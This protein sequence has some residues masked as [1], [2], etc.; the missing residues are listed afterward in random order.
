MIYIAVAKVEFKGKRREMMIAFDINDA[1]KI[2]TIHPIREKQK[3]NRVKS[4]RWI[5]W[6]RKNGSEKG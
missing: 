2:V 1:V 5:E 4:G 3:E 6:R